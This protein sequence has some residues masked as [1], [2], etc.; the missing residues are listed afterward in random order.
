MNKKDFL[1][2]W[3]EIQGK[4]IDIKSGYVN[5]VFN[6][7]AVIIKANDLGRDI[8]LTFDKPADGQGFVCL[9]STIRSIIEITK[10]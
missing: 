8:Y 5:P 10:K 3:P 2:I 7:N 1:K 6:R 4:P 9:P